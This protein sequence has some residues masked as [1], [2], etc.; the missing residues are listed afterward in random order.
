MVLETAHPSKFIDEVEKVLD[1]KITIPDRLAVLA[2]K[3]KVATF[4]EPQFDNFKSWLL[5]NLA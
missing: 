3:K 4:M 2:D 5:D 1:R